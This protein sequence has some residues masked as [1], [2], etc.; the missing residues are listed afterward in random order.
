M[1]TER[2]TG[3]AGTKLTNHFVL[4][5][6]GWS[7]VRGECV[8]RTYEAEG[9][10]P[11]VVC[12][13]VRGN[14]ATSISNAC[15]HLVAE[16]VGE[17]Y[18]HLLPRTRRADHR[19]RENPPFRWIVHYPASFGS[20]EAQQRAARGEYVNFLSGVEWWFGVTFQSYRINRRGHLCLGFMRPGGKT[21]RERVEEL[22]G[23]AIG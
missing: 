17:L 6:E 16:V 2:K 10:P 8:I 20:K 23:N 13:A 21:T 15:E 22:V 7:E 11:V 12:S 19:A 18:P 1:T 4:E 3:E 9:E 14:R 5:Y